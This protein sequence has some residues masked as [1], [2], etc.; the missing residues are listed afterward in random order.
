MKATNVLRVEHEAIKLMLRILE[1]YVKNLEMGK[2]PNA[3]H[4]EK[5]LEFFSVFADKC[6]H[7]KE[8]GMLFPALE[9]AGVPKDGG[10]LAIMLKEHDIGRGLIKKMREGL[11]KLKA[12][13]A[14]S[15]RQ[16][17]EAAKD[18]INLLTLHIDKENEILFP[19]ADVHLSDQK[20]EELYNRFEEYE[21]KEIGAGKH[22]E[23]HR[24][25]NH[26]KGVYLGSL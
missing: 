9:E 12:N 22:E 1:A 20:Q 17:I 10:P 21:Q 4:L 14:E 7:G 6:H 3:E 26:F 25:L 23:F 2:K 5:M 16:I 13:S 19:A 8:E 15:R 11:Q 24:I 18:Y